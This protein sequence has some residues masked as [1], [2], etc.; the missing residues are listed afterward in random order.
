MLLTHSL[1]DLSI[2]DIA[3]A[4][5]VRRTGFYFYFPSKAVAVA[6]LLDE[7]YDETLA[8]AEQ[9]TGRASDRTAALREAIGRL[10]ELWQRHRP[11]MLAVLDA[12]SRDR[13]AAQIWERWLERYVTPAADVITADRAAGLAPPGPEPATMLR[14]LLVMNERGL[15]RMLR[16]G[17]DA[18]EADRE[19]N[20][21]ASIWSR[22]IYGDVKAPPIRRRR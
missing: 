11:L 15:E 18:V 7:L 17:V 5:G 4:A 10:W 2:N 9:F 22:A 19:L 3:A 14:L 1:E 13:E 20:A 21:L 8:G 6:T 12:R 16:N